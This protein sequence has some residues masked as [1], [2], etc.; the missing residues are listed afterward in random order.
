MVHQRIQLVHPLA[1]LREGPCQLAVQGLEGIGEHVRGDLVGK[2]GVF[3]T[4]PL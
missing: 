4:A 1:H 3:V 2:D